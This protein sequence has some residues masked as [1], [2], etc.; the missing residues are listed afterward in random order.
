MTKPS[1]DGE[2]FYALFAPKVESRLRTV[3]S[4]TGTHT[5]YAQAALNAEAD[6]VRTATEGR[7]NAT[8]NQ[9]AFSLGQLVA[10]GEL[11]EVAVVAALTDAAA[12]AGLEPG[13]IHATIRSGLDGGGRHP[14]RTPEPPKEQRK[15][16][17]AEGASQ[18]SECEALEAAAIFAREVTLEAYRLRVR[19]S[20]R[21]QVAQERALASPMPPFDAGLLSEVLARPAEPPHRVQGLIPSD[22]GTLVVA[23][24]KTGKT[25]MLLNLARSLILGSDFLGTFPVRPVTGRV[26]FLNFEVSA[27][28]L[29]RWAD[30]SGV[31]ADRFYQV[32]LRGRR[33]PF[34]LDVDREQLATHLREHEI[35]SLIVDPFGRAYVGK[36]QND[37]GEVG[38]WLADLDRFARGDAGIADVVLAA[39]AGWDGERTR[40]SS[41][42][43]DW[44]DSIITMVRDKDDD[45]GRFLRAEGRDVLVDEDRLDFEPTTR[46]LTLAG[47]GSRKTAAKTRHLEELIPIV[48]AIVKGD[49]GIS[50]Y[51][52]EQTLRGQGTHFQRGDHSKALA[53]AVERRLIRFDPGARNAKNYHPATT[54]PDLPRHAPSGVRGDLPR[55]PLYMEGEVTRGGEANHLP[56][57]HLGFTCGACGQHL[58]TDTLAGTGL[59]GACKLK[60]S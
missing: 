12:D 59:C 8:L 49:P 37:P 6:N 28:Q 5:P 18:D 35:E 33:N 26:G 56:Q 17:T 50:G 3:T 27:A 4:Q 10:G 13:E 44:A 60:A 32:N 41:A 19:E 11:T 31:P 22:A 15:A 23:Q 1:Q 54:Y 47:A 21:D 30:E 9:S 55:P 58:S 34:G 2:A 7:R 16:T 38:S 46:T 39:H 52:V 45:Q 57:P 36:S 24:R 25:T 14:R 40:G 48:V 42:L 53:A 20:A 43:E 51:K 29:A